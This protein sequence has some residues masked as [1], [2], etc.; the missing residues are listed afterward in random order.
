MSA[1]WGGGMRRREEVRGG[2][3]EAGG[4]GARQGTTDRQT[5]PRGYYSRFGYWRAPPNAAR[6]ARLM[7]CMLFPRASRMGDHADAN[8]WYRGGWVG[9]AR[10]KALKRRAVGKQR[11]FRA[12][13]HRQWIVTCISERV[14]GMP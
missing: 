10:Q 12:G 13:H 3:G 8:V 5:G 6:T 11:L 14:V 9:G 1:L 2:Y 7:G 4:G